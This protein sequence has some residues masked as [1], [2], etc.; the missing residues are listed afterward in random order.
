MSMLANFQDSWLTD[1]GEV[2]SLTCKP[3]FTPRRFLLLIS[4]VGWVNSRPIVRLEGLGKLRDP[5]TLS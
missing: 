1:G 3:P 4:I 2:V 5:V